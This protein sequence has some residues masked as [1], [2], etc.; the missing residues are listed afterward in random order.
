MLSPSPLCADAL[1]AQLLNQL[2]MQGPPQQLAMSA[3]SQEGPM[4]GRAE[5]SAGL[6]QGAIQT[7][8]AQAGLNMNAGQAAAPGMAQALPQA[9]PAS[10]SLMLSAQGTTAV[11][12]SNGQA[13][14]PGGTSPMAVG[15][16]QSYAGMGVPPPPSLPYP[17][18]GMQ[19]PSA[20]LLSTSPS[21]ASPPP[22]S[23]GRASPFPGLSAAANAA[24]LSTR[25]A[26]S[27]DSSPLGRYGAIGTSVAHGP[28]LESPEEALAARM[29]ALTSADFGPRRSDNDTGAAEG[30]SPRHSPTQGM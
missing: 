12:G 2:S 6:D 8:L 9:P 21:T 15:S 17:A 22:G 3:G 20:A 1:L 4:P 7:L 16:P 27:G 24:I 26:A 11:L 14:F 29:G 10:A 19:A 13:A 28:G 18:A 5:P 23:S 30:A 25:R